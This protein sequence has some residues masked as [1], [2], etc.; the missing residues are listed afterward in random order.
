MSKM[1][2]AITHQV[3]LLL[4]L[5]LQGCSEQPE[6]CREF[7]DMPRQQRQTQFRTFPVEKQIEAYLCAMKEEPPDLSLAEQ[8]AD[9]GESALPVLLRQLKSSSR[10]IDQEDII[11][12]LEVMSD[13]GYLRGRKDVIADISQVIDE[14]KIDQVKQRCAESLKKIERNSG[15][16][17]FTYT[18]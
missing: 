16:K 12:V 13:R 17:S 3:V 8:L 11:Y 5:S 18:Q 1:T 2:L 4:C 10:E 7:L 14:M 6:A 9:G 15:V